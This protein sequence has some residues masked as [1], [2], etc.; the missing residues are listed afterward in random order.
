LS[1][2]S[3]GQ[4]LTRPRVLIADDDD[5]IRL[6]CKVNLELAGIDVLEA[7]DGNEAVTLARRESPDVAVLDVTMPGLDGWQVA[8]KLRNDPATRNIPLVFLTAVPPL[9]AREGIARWQGKYIGKP[10]D[11][12]ELL[13]AIRQAV[14][15]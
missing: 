11:A 6:L 15:P 3:G 10:F 7:A 14:A 12:A 9:H 4:R 8:E 2:A 5:P 13:A 1:E